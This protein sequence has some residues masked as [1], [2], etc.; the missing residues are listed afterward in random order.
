MEIN[1][2][3]GVPEVPEGRRLR[4][5]KKDKKVE[6][7]K[8]TSGTGAHGPDEVSLSEAARRAAEVARYTRIAKSGEQVRE[9]RVRQAEENIKKGTHTKPE[10]I[11][12]TA[13]RV[14]EDI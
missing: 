6:E 3:A 10:V 13:K 5:E 7:R 9:V 1:R 14:L 8:P 11:K 12:E 4:G 2:I